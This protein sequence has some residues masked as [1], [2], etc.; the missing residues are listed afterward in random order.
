MKIRKFIAG[1]AVA[2]LA[3]LGVGLTAQSASAHTPTASATCEALTVDATY[4]ETKPGTPESGTPTIT[5]ANPDY[6]PATEGTASVW[7]VFSPNDSQGTFQGPPT[8]PTDARG[9]WQVK[10]ELPGG[11]AGP[12]GVYQNGNG[13]G[14]WFYRAAAIPG[15]P[16]VGEPNITVPNPDYKP[17]TPGDNAPNT[18][19]VTIDGTQVVSTT[20]GSSYH[21][22]IPFS[23]KTVAHTWS[24][25]ITAW[26]DPQ[27]YNGW[28]KTISGTTTPCVTEVPPVDFDKLSGTI[29]VDCEAETVTF[30]AKNENDVAVTFLTQFDANGDGT[31][32][33]GDGFEVGANASDTSVYDFSLFEPNSTLTAYLLVA[34]GEGTHEVAKS[35]EFTTKSC[36]EV[37]PAPA[38]PT[39]VITAVCG[40]ADIVLTNPVGENANQLTASFVVKVDGKVY[41]TPAVVAG[42]SQEIHLTFPEDSGDHTVEVFQ[43][44]TSEWKSIA[45]KTVKSDCILPQPKDKVTNGDWS[46]PVFDCKSEAG[47]EVA[48]ERTVTTTP[49]KL[50][51]GEW[52]LDTEN[53]KTTTEDGTYTVTAEDIE[54]LDCA[55]VVPPTEQPKP[56]PS[57]TPAPPITGGL[58][59]T[60]G[61]PLVTL[62]ALSGG[63]LMVALGALAVVFEARRR[64]LAKQ[65]ADIE[66]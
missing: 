26:N 27:G 52:V 17:A 31:P 13:N 49:Y 46:K 12:N 3:T 34:D 42:E 57:T 62:W 36:A 44:G 45:K 66:V 38:N 23:D 1:A 51:E 32:D 37:P 60:G 39:A 9:T 20:F 47:D 10:G 5:K 54:A 58:A 22:V 41:D 16:A 56:T 24:V 33:S 25:T 2:V 40:A 59:A 63:A 29:T 18:V 28:T 14:S 15:T 19:V 50:V 30:T 6:K 55:V 4:Y 8:Y 35:A 61:D 48:I 21:N 11:H 53:A 7:A 43:A 64:Q 65:K